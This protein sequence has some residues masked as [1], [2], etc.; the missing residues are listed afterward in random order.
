MFV[1]QRYAARALAGSVHLL[2]GCVPRIGRVGVVPVPTQSRTRHRSWLCGR[3]RGCAGRC[4]GE[5]RIGQ[6]R[7]NNRP[8][9]PVS[10]VPPA[11][12]EL[13]HTV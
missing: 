7:R 4:G 3:M 6:I 12:I 1:I 11:R 8:Q 13:A 10:A 9:T 2:E 5:A